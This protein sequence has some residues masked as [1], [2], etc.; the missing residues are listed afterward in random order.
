M[1]AGGVQRSSGC[2]KTPLRAEETAA[3]EG[4]QPPY[5][6]ACRAHAAN[7]QPSSRPQAHRTRAWRPGEQQ[8]QIWL[9]LQKFAPQ[10]YNVLQD[11]RKAGFDISSCYSFLAA[12]AILHLDGKLFCRRRRKLDSTCYP[13]LPSFS[14]RSCDVQVTGMKACTL[15]VVMHGSSH[16][17]GSCQTVTEDWLLALA[18]SFAQP[19]FEAPYKLT[20]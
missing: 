15:C 5:S 13:F 3:A 4:C 14:R 11:A 16:A 2:G 19:P 10:W 17:H 9:L 1:H 7:S 6:G 18:E 8:R 12:P 20:S